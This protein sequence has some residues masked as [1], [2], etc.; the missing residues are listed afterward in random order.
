MNDERKAPDLFAS[1]QYFR[2][3]AAAV[4]VFRIKTTTP[5]HNPL[6]LTCTVVETRSAIYH[7]THEAPAASY[8]PP[9]ILQ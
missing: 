3:L 9:V 7:K 6:S 1:Q 8:Q 4:L 2:E 5:A